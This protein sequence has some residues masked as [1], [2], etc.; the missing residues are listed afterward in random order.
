MYKLVSIDMDGTLLNSHG[1]I[2]E[3]NLTAI[4]KALDKGVKI[5]F[6]TGRGIVSISRFIKQVGLDDKD[7]YA[8]TN[9]GVSLYNTKTLKCLKSNVISG[10]DLTYLCKLGLEFGTKIHVYDAITE[11]C[12]VLEENEFANFERDHIGMP[13]YV[14]PNFCDDDGEDK[15]AFKVLYLG[16]E[17][18]LDEIQKR[19]PDEVYEKYAVV[20]SLP[21]VLEIFKKECNKGNAVKDLAEIF[22][23]SQNEIISIGDQQNDYEMIK[24]AGLGVAMGNAID[25]LKE[26][27]D[28]V[29]DTNDNNGVS[30][31]INKFIL[32]ENA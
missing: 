29:T 11:G 24:F 5:V 30:K 14:K 31:V 32:D 15:K 21:I 10:N 1:E 2:S 22:G 16:D 26:I 19:I 12:I 4:K 25:S 18:E 27:A 9:N 3:E 23:F 13:V 20:R 17:G 7:E 28:Y 6:T 8:I